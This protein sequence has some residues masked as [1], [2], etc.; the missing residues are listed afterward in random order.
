MNIFHKNYDELF[1][2]DNIFLAWRIFR[3]GKAGK[4]EVMDFEMHLEDHLFRLF[5]QLRVGRYRHLLYKFF[6]IFDN[7]KR[8]IHKAE[9]IDRIVHQIVYDH[10]LS[11]F[12]PI[13]I[14]D[15]YASRI[16]KGQYRAIDTLRYFIKLAGDRDGDCYVLKCDVRK[17]FDSIDQKILADLIGEK[18]FCDETMDIIRE[19]VSS[20]SS[21]DPGKGIPLGNVTSQI[22][23]NIYLDI[24]DQYVKN[25]LKCRF[26]IRYNDDLAV[27][28]KDRAELEKIRDK[29]MTFARQKL[30]L[31]IP[32]E[33][34]SIRK[35]GWG[36]DFLGFTVLPRSVLLRNKTKNKIYSNI[37]RKNIHSYMSILR[38]CD[39]YNLRKKI[40]S[41]VNDEKQHIV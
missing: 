32:M 17:Y 13:F 11:I 39:S 10:L 16:D 20:Y 6:Q 2:L 35:I 27:I 7:K 22:F 24:L 38:H 29:I 28:S 14:R 37:S 21:I 3:R 34:T 9:I 5:E 40:I 26:Y 33:K 25:E 15:S 23:A 36:V 31:E 41:R 1:S 18:V 4:R 8:D 19:I 30:S 12:E